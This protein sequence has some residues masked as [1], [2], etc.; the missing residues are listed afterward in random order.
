MT[1][2][3][4]W[5]DFEEFDE[6]PY[7]P[8]DPRQPHTEANPSPWIPGGEILAGGLEPVAKQ[9][10][11]TT[12]HK[13]GHLASNP[14]L[15]DWTTID[16][17]M[18]LPPL[19]ITGL[20]SF[21]VDVD[22]ALSNP[23]AYAWMAYVKTIQSHRDYVGD[24]IRNLEP[25][26]HLFFRF[27]IDKWN[28]PDN[29]IVF[30]GSFFDKA[31]FIWQAYV[32]LKGSSRNLFLWYLLGS[33]DWP[34]E[35][36]EYAGRDFVDHRIDSATTVSLG[37][38]HTLEVRRVYA[39]DGE[40]RVWLDGVEIADLAQIGIDTTNLWRGPDTSGQYSELCT[41]QPPGTQYRCWERSRQTGW[42][43][44]SIHGDGNLPGRYAR[45][46]YD[47]VILAA[48]RIGMVHNLSVISSP[49]SGIPFTVE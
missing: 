24:T 49:I 37:D 34:V 1:V 48:E 29:N 14:S 4:F 45:I 6:L 46:V 15:W 21:Y 16:P 39:V 36:I 31:E 2:R 11:S 5:D 10:A 17:E 42:T 20:R 7:Q 28:V 13:P 9:W 19:P 35:E 3:Y 18:N 43:I 27:R 41:D 38:V 12:D 23:K 44:G 40:I 33:M 8:G 26:E 32:G 47:D 22:L 30:L 25:I